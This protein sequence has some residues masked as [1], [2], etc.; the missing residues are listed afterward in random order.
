MWPKMYLVPALIMTLALDAALGWLGHQRPWVIDR[1]LPG[2]FRSWGPELPGA[3][4]RSSLCHPNLKRVGA[5]RQTAVTAGTGWDIF[6]TNSDP[7]FSSP[8]TAQ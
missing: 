6:F 7:I 1:P 3:N 2:K 5:E 4:P 8:Q